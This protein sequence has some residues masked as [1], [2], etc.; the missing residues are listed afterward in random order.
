[1]KINHID[2]MISQ[3]MTDHSKY[4]RSCNE[5]AKACSEL[6]TDYE[7]ITCSVFNSDGL[8]LEVSYYDESYGYRDMVIPV[9]SFIKFI[10]DKT[11]SVKAEDLY[12]IAI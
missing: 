8:V 7:E 3:C 5:V 12:I 2:S 4:W 10:E 9:D 6:V 11:N 1:M